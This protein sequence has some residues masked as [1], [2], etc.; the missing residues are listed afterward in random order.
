[1][2]RNIAPAPVQAPARAQQTT[3]LREVG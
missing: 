1:M 3:T 2:K